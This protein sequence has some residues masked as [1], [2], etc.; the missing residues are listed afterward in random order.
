M[1]IPGS[2]IQEEIKANFKEQEIIRGEIQELHEDL[3][4]LQKKIWPEE[5]LAFK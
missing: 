1:P 4:D 3:H 2:D 5:D